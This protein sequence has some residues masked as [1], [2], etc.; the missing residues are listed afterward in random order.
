LKVDSSRFKW[1]ID[2]KP[3]LY[4]L[5]GM[6]ASPDTSDDLD[7]KHSTKDVEISM[8]EKIDRCFIDVL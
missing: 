2:D 1:D 5:Y 7:P 6:W 4:D 3:M 8:D